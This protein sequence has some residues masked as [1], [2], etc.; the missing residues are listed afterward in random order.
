MVTAVTAPGGTQQRVD[1]IRQRQTELEEMSHEHPLALRCR[2]LIPR[3]YPHL[4]YFVEDIA[5]GCVLVELG[6][7]DDG[8]WLQCDLRR[9]CHYRSYQR[10]RALHTGS[11]DGCEQTTTV[12][13][14]CP[15]TRRPCDR[16]RLAVIVSLIGEINK[17]RTEIT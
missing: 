4:A 11:C 12:K 17:P 3:Y 8:S 14:I 15:R 9:V 13:G 16:D 2:D 10:E 7:W 5:V 1:Q 6:L